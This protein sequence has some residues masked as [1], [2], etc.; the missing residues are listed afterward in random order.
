[1]GLGRV[2]DKLEAILGFPVNLDTPHSRL[3][4]ILRSIIDGTAYTEPPLSRIEEDFLA[5]VNGARINVRLSRVEEMLY[6]IIEGL[7]YTDPRLSRV[8]QLLEELDVDMEDKRLRSSDYYI[9]FSS[10]RHRLLTRR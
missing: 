3:E 2:E 4:K 1:M 9:L 5:Y 8:E 6:A 10:D 7:D